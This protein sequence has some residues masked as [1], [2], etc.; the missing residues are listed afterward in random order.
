MDEDFKQAI[1]RKCDLSMARD[2]IAHMHKLVSDEAESKGL[3][4]YVSPEYMTAW[5]AFRDHPS[6]DNAAKFLELSPTTLRYFEV[7]CPGTMIYE[8]NMIKRRWG[9]T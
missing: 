5:E 9:V 6:M 7:C 8:G 1:L 3:G 4:Y 2:E